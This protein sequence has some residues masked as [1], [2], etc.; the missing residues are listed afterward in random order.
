MDKPII[1]SQASKDKNNVTMEIHS[2]PSLELTLVTDGEVRFSVA[3]HGYDLHQGEL[4]V[5]PPETEHDQRPLEH[6]VTSFMSFWMSHPEDFVSSCRKIDLTLETWGRRLF[7]EICEM[8]ENCRYDLCESM[9]NTLILELKKIEENKS[10]HSEFHPALRLAVENLEARFA[11]NWSMDEL[12]RKC[13]VSVSYLRRLFELQF[14]MSPQ[15]YLQNCR[16]ANARKMLFDSKMNISEI[17]RLCGY[18]DS[19]YFTR[20]F[21]K[22]H[23]CTPAK[24]RWIIQTRPESQ[25]IRQ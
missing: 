21:H 20:L 16:M 13:A 12:A 25:N 3:G 18:D 17:G 6:S 7:Q 11:Y 10:S 19:A 2:H 1:F 22:L 9:L 14:N 8:S 5:I 24:Y 15:K 4:L 23:H